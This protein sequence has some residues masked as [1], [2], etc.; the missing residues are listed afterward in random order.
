MNVVLF[1]PPPHIKQGVTRSSLQKVN[2]GFQ[3]PNCFPKKKNKNQTRSWQ[4]THTHTERELQGSDAGGNSDQTAA[5]PKKTWFKGF[6]N[7]WQDV[8]F[9]RKF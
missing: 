6:K 8:A 2:V 7:F 5:L 4:H 1:P 9:N 3:R